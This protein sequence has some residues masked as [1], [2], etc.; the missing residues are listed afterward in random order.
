MRKLLKF[1]FWIVLI[2]IVAI[3]TIY[4]TAGIWI[5]SVVS[6]VVPQITQTEASLDDAD[7]SI[8]KGK[9]ALKG[10]RIAN[11]T[12]FSEPNVFE[13]KEILVH[14]EP[15]SLFQDKIIINEIKIDGT[16]IDAELAKNGNINL[17]LLNNNIQSYLGSPVP[18]Q[19]GV[20]ET[21]KV[22][23]TESS[24]NKTVLIKDLQILDSS[25]KLTLLSNTKEIKLPTIHE[26]NIGEKNKTTIEKAIADIFSE[27]LMI[28]FS[29]ISASGKDA[30]NFMLNDLTMRTKDAAPIRDIVN[31]LF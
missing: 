2:L 15:T 31:Q 29:Q 19:M 3:I 12:G 13:F 26:K 24:S 8:F 5:R 14:F 7:I 9:L 16:K 17:M 22:A 30:L 20:K 18:T 25:L 11:P 4:L 28:S 10:F 23:K 21:P 6:T 1:L 27:L